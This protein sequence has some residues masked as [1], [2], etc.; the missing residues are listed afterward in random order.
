[1]D[2]KNVHFGYNP[3]KIIINDFTF[4]AEPGQKIAIVG[5]TGA[6]KTTMV[7]LLMRFYDVNSGAILVDGHNI[8]DFTRADLRC[9]FG[10]VLQD[11]WLYNGPIMENIRYG[12]SNASD[13]EVINAAKAAR[14]DHF[15]RT[16]PEG[17]N[18]VLNEE[19]TNI[20]QGQMQL[21]TIARAFLADPKILILDEATSSVDTHTEVQIQKAMDSLMKGRTSFIIAHRLSTIRDADWIL[22]MKDGD[23]VEQGKHAKLLAKKGFY[24]ELYNSQ[25]EGKEI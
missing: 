7:K 18:M 22:V 15:V 4:Y 2:F 6:G 21:M 13:E 1:V 23:I 8:Q 20:S 25:F 12:R 11:T 10:M 19:T 14:V 24:A 16:L 9:M 5:P 3:D 17:Y